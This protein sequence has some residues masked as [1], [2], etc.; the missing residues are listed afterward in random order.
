MTQR[1]EILSSLVI[2]RPHHVVICKLLDLNLFCE[3]TRPVG[4]KLGSCLMVFN[5]TFNNILVISWQ[6]VLLVE[7]TKGPRENCPD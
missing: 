6:T 1:L 4:T 3:T 7:E 5:T 2:S